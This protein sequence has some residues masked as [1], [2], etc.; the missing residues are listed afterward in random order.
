MAMKRCWGIGAM[1]A[2]F[3]IAGPAFGGEP[4][5]LGMSTW[6]GYAPLYLAKEKGLFQ[7][8]GLEVEV[9]VIESPADRRA[10]FAADRIQG[11]A[12]TVDTHVMT[13]AA[14]NPIPLKQVLALDDS[15]G[16][17]GMVAKK[18]IKTIKDLKG[19]TVAAQLGA[20]ASYF[21]LNYV[22]SQNGMKLSDLKTVDMKAGDAGAAF[23]AGKV[24]AAV[25][26][27]PWLSKAKDT[28]FGHVLLSSDQTPGIIVDSLA[29]KPDFLK[30]RAEDVKKIVAAWNE[31][32]Q[33]AAENPTEADAIMAKFT[34][35]K[36]EEFTKEKTG[37]RFYG[38]KENKEYFGTPQK[39]G[40]LYKVT[41]R[42]ADVWSQLKFIKTKPKA[43][44]LID[45]SFL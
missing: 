23:V 2:A 35:Q 26:W 8:R 16:G 32:V 12:T 27:E 6:L 29:F 5:K 15:H 14:E 28:P 1:L 45:G 33:L 20:G 11:M 18:E 40:L 3:L 13:A 24:D 4:I 34:G 7:K 22:L 30:K 25:T 31:A 38:Q 42:A 37:V 41:Q 36:P 17:D 21:W 43:T 9:V 44:D 39:P 10:A 19:K